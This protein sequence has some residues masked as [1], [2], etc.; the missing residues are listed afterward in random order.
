MKRWCRHIIKDDSGERPETWWFAD[1]GSVVTLVAFRHIEVCD[2]WRSCPICGK[3]R[4]KE[5]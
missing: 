5:K 3:P 2:T 4:P 1:T